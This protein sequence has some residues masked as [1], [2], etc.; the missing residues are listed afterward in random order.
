MVR[1]QLKKTFSTQWKHYNEWCLEEGWHP[2]LSFDCTQVMIE[3]ACDSLMAFFSYIKLLLQSYSNFC[4]NKSIVAKGFRIVFSFEL[5]ADVF[6]QR[7][8]KGLENRA[9]PSA[10]A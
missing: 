7:V 2:W 8:D 6:Y 5:G 1:P 3:H 4:N 9:T 10:S